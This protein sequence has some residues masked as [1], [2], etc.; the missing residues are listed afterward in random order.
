VSDLA[1]WRCGENYVVRIRGNEHLMTLDE[2]S[3]LIG[4][5][6]NVQA[7]LDKSL[8]AEYIE[9]SNRRK[10]PINLSGILSGLGIAK[11]KLRRI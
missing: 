5:L 10:A 4:H 2:L 8:G 6:Q 11:P 1:C 9:L 3:E 7:G